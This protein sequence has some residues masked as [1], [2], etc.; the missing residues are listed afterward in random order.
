ML[1]N[2]CP[3]KH[4]STNQYIKFMSEIQVIKIDF[5]LPQNSDGLKQAEQKIGDIR[6][7][8]LNIITDDLLDDKTHEELFDRTALVLDW[9]GRMSTP[10]FSIRDNLE[11]Q[12]EKLYCKSPNLARKLFDDHYCNLHRP[13][14]RL[15]NKC[16]NILDELDMEYE[17]KFKKKPLN[18]IN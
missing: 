17:K 11:A 9:I 8:F 13:Y 1:S 5:N 18:W 10:V 4:L 14:S 2:Q 6:R 12:Y 7:D 16:F 15:K 3:I